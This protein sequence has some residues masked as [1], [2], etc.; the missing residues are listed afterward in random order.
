M[1]AL[2]LEKGIGPASHEA[3]FFSVQFLYP[4]PGNAKVMA[5]GIDQ[6]I[7]QI[8]EKKLSVFHLNKILLQ[9]VQLPRQLSVYKYDECIAVLEEQNMAYLAEWQHSRW[10]QGELIL[11][12]SP[13]L[14]TEICG[15]RLK[16]D[17]TVGLLCEKEK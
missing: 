4:Y 6:S 15:Y 3:L 9:R 5:V 8:R 14:E 10:L 12:L 2:A 7:V 17:Q 13:H 11:L 1:P 16:Y